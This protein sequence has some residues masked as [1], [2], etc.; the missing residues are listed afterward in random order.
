MK[1]LFT[2]PTLSLRTETLALL[3]TVQLATIAGGLKNAS[4]P[5]VCLTM[6][7]DCQSLGVQP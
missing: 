4:R 7:D 3:T 1:K 2:R 5:S 6:C